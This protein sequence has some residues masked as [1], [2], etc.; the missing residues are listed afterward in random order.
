[1]V[2][3]VTNLMGGHGGMVDAVDSKSTVRKDVGVQVPLPADF[4]SLRDW[5]EASTFEDALVGACG[6]TKRDWLEL[7]HLQQGHRS[8]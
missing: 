5:R 4:I 6:A 2:D 8:E 3:A 7:A 1:M